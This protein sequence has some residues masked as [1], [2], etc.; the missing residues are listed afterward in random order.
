M[1]TNVTIILGEEA[2]GPHRTPALGMVL[3]AN[4]GWVLVPLYVLWRAMAGP[5]VPAA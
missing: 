5:A 3:A 1:L 4:A 2:F